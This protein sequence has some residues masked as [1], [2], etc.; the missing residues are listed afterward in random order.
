MGALWP[1]QAGFAQG[2]VDLEH[3]RQATMQVRTARPHHNGHPIISHLISL[4]RSG[5][6]LSKYLYC[7]APFLP[8]SSECFSQII[9]SILDLIPGLVRSTFLGALVSHFIGRLHSAEA[10]DHDERH[11]EFR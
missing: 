5:N 3:G 8:F 6:D 4:S 7:P 9:D 2:G 10:L 1:K 11:K